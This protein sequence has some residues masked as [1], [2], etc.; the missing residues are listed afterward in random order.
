MYRGFSRTGTVRR[1][2]ITVGEW[3]ELVAVVGGTIYRLGTVKMGVLLIDRRVPIHRMNI[4]SG[5]VPDAAACAAVGMRFEGV[6]EELNRDNI[7]L[8]LNQHPNDPLGPGNRIDL[9]GLRT[10]QLFFT[11]RGRRPNALMTNEAFLEFCLWKCRMANLL[12]LAGKDEADGVRFSAVAIDDSDGDFGGNQTAPYGWFTSVDSGS[13]APT[14]TPAED[15]P[16]W[17]D[18]LPIF[19]GGLEPGGGWGDGIP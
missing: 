9:D 11:L 6:L 15:E 14:P 18:G 3:T 13:D 2:A 19:P 16:D 12:Q 10:P 1:Q 17:G 5:K 7:R 8:L 4:G